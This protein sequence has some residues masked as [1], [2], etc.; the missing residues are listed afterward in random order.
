ML[1]CSCGSMMTW[2]LAPDDFSTLKTKRRRRCWSC[3][4]FIEIGSECLEMERFR[5]ADSDIE[6][7]I[8][9]GEVPLATKYLC[10]KCGEIYLNLSDLGYCLSLGK[11]AMQ[12]AIEDYWELTK[13]DPE[14]YKRKGGQIENKNNPYRFKAHSK[15][16]NN[17][18]A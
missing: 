6:E 15:Q 12:E 8:Y 7:R 18:M 5:C 17:G 1:S 16:G 14:K 10:E 9:G 3:E 11:G 13:F 4:K 2:F